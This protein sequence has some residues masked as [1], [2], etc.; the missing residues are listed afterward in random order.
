MQGKE[1]KLQLRA[2]LFISLSYW[3]LW[4]LLLLMSTGNVALILLCLVGLV[5]MV[6]LWSALL[7]AFAEIL[8][9]KGK[10]TDVFYLNMLFMTPLVLLLIF[11]WIAILFSESLILGPGWGVEGTW[12]SK[13]F[14]FLMFLAP[15]IVTL[16]WFYLIYLGVK[17]VYG[18]SKKEAAITV[19]LSLAT[20]AILICVVIPFLSGFGISLI[21]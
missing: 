14:I 3:F 9:G 19:I 8:G 13:S 18:I 5:L 17:E 11:V 4:V 2:G 12:K 15:F 21:R 10:V 16:E 1:K 6:G 7:Q 20:I